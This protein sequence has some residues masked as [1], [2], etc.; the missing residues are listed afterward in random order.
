MELSTKNWRTHGT[1]GDAP[2]EKQL[3]HDYLVR[4]VSNM[5]HV[6]SNLLVPL[7]HMLD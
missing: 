1:D 3:R 5:L 4:I 2:K 6:F 7:V